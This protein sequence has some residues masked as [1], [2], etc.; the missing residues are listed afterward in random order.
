MKHLWFERGAYASK[1][2]RKYIQD[3]FQPQKSRK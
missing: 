2:A 3:D 1:K